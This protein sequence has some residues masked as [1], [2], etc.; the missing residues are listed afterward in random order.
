[1]SVWKLHFNQTPWVS[2]PQIGNSDAGGATCPFCVGGLCPFIHQVHNLYIF[3][4]IFQYR[5]CPSI[6]S[7]ENWKK[8]EAPW[9][10][11]K[12]TGWTG[13]GNVEFR[14]RIARETSTQAWKTGK[15]FPLT[16]ASSSTPPS[17]LVSYIYILIHI[18]IHICIFVTI[19]TFVYVF[20]YICIHT[21]TKRGSAWYFGMLHVF[22]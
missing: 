20:V 14:L 22:K 18:C 5:P 4:L 6:S 8:R 2:C 11:Q 19:C 3:N 9:V 1:M 13:V 15:E 12:P 17:L 7:Y 16:I 21:R 10:D